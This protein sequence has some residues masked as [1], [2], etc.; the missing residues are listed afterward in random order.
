[1]KSLFPRH[2][3]KKGCESS[4]LQRRMASVVVLQPGVLAPGSLGSGFETDRAAIE[5][6]R[7]VHLMPKA[8][9]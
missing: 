2:L 8:L 5:H 3:R 9:P 4:F 7:W 1:M 6:A